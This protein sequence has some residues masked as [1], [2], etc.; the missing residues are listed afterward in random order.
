MEQELKGLSLYELNQRWFA[1]KQ[2]ATGVEN[3]AETVVRV[4]GTGNMGA[5]H[6]A[7]QGSD[8]QIHL[9]EDTIYIWYGSDVVFDKQRHQEASRIV[10]DDRWYDELKT[11]YEE[12]VEIDMEKK[13]RAL[14]D[15]L[16]P[17]RVEL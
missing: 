4:L 5:F 2:W 7:R 6:F 8:V 13:R 10:V 17:A 1:A 16:S 9:D 12:A 15:Q 11:L 3:R 14:I